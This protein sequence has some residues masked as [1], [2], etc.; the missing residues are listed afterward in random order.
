MIV[1]LAQALDQNGRFGLPSRV[2]HNDFKHMWA[3]GQILTRGENPYPPDAMFA[4]ARNENLGSINPF[5]YPPA[6]ALL[7]RPVTWL[8]FGHAASVWYALNW[9][10]AWCCVLAAPS[11]LR[12]DRP[13]LARIAGAAFLVYSLPFYRQMTSGQMNVALLTVF[14]LTPALLIRRRDQVAGIVLGFGAAFKVA[15]I[16]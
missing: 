13:D 10:L 9:I 15:P 6:T 7:M 5:V 14:V 2:H 16:F 11:L 12:M 1:S 8:S 3:G 4:E